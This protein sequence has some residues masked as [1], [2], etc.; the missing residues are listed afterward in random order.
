MKQT[1]EQIYLKDTNL[2]KQNEDLRSGML[3]LEKNNQEF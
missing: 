3:E 2:V 1:E